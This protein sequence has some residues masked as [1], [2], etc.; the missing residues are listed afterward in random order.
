[1]QKPSENWK[2]LR[3]SALERARRNTIKPLEPLCKVYIGASALFLVGFLRFRFMDQPTEFIWF[4]GA[5]IIAVAI[6]GALIPILFGSV[7]T[8]HF[9]DRKLERLLSE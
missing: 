2:R 5:S 9:A 4:E 3:R 8:L 7:L 6:A 1:M